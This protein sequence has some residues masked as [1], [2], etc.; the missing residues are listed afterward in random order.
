MPPGSILEFD[1]AML[2]RSAIQWL[3]IIVLIVFL[4]YLLYKPVKKFMADRV[5]RINRDIESARRNSEKARE[6]RTHYERLIA[7]IEEEREEILNQA[8]RVAV[9]RSDQ[10]LLA[11]R[12]EAKHMKAKADDEIRIERENAADDIKNQIIELSTLMASRF[13]EI[14]IDRETQEK[15][16]SEMLSDWREWS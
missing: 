1:M 14:S 10:I 13:V 11:A 12:E 3:N 4:T 2:I 8:H 15:L 5:A 6:E 7:N 9:E 16:V